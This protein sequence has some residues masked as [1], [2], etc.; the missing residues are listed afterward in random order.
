M[1]SLSDTFGTPALHV[2]KPGSDVVEVYPTPGDDPF[3]SEIDAF[4]DVV[5]GKPNAKILSGYEDA[6]K[7]YEMTWAIRNSAE[8]WTRRLSQRQGRTWRGS[9]E[10]LFHIWTMRQ[11]NRQHC[12]NL[13]MA[14]SKPSEGFCCIMGWQM[15]D[16]QKVYLS[17]FIYILRYDQ[18]T[19]VSAS[20][21]KRRTKQSMQLTMGWGT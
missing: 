3:Q 16:C 20:F 17:T 18:P 6:A 10:S 15:T 19:E 4:I 14:E 9:V 8:E 12:R 21:R 2:R 11:M 13:I 1:S 7:T 5:E